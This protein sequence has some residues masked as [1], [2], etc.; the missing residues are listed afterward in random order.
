MANPHWHG[1]QTITH[2]LNL[3]R[4]HNNLRKFLLINQLNKVL[5]GFRKSQQDC[6]SLSGSTVTTTLASVLINHKV[7]VFGWTKREEKTVWLPLKKSLTNIPTAMPRQKQLF[8]S[9]CELCLCVYVSIW[10]SDGESERRKTMCKAFLYHISSNN[11]LVGGQLSLTAHLLP[12][13]HKNTFTRPI[14]REKEN[15]EGSWEQMSLV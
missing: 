13:P 1:F 15:S 5:L 3:K 7:C 9:R 10:Q 6:H 4:G 12:Y 11:W 8:Q 2:V 14:I